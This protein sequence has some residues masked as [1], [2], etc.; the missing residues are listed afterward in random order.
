[1]KTGS[2]QILAFVGL[3][4]WLGFVAGTR[5]VSPPLR[6]DEAPTTALQAVSGVGAVSDGAVRAG[7]CTEGAGKNLLLAQAG[8]AATTTALVAQPASAAKKPN[9]VVIMG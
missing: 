4:A 5:G 2:L 6:A 7:C 8:V 9:I 3:G 1:M